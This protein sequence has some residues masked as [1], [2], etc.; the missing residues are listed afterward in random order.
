MGNTAKN[1]KILGEVEDA[2]EF[3]SSHG[4]M[5]VP[6]L[7][8]RGMRIKIIEGMACSCPIISTSIGAEGIQCIDG[9]NIL[10]ANTTAVFTSKLVSLLQDEKEAINLGKQ[11]RKNIKEHYTN[12]AITK[13]LVDFYKK[14]LS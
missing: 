6:L 3:M 7:S 12:E 11:A 10:L 1:I 4:I 5:V 2:V 13:E 14:L 9:E 8:G